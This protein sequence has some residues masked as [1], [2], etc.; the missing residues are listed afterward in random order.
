MVIS[1][2]ALPRRIEMSAVITTLAWASFSRVV[3]VCTEPGEDHPVDGA[4]PGT[5]QH[6]DHLFGD[7]RHVD[8][9][10]VPFVTPTS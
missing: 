2:I 6:G 1:G 5:G 4:D 9:D 8:A 3:S 7:H 10:P